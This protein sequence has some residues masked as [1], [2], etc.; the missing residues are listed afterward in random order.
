MDNL[1][2]KG[3]LINNVCMGTERPSRD[4][5]VRAGECNES[6]ECESDGGEEQILKKRTRKSVED[7]QM[8]YDA[9]PVHKR[10]K[11]SGDIENIH[12]SNAQ[13]ETEVQIGRRRGEKRKRETEEST[14]SAKRRRK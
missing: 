13:L 3:E 2:A 11:L 4:P 9:E 5:L 8:E 6:K 14:P 12:E 7:C 1:K 10:R